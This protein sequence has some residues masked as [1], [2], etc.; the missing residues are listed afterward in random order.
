MKA[1][2]VLRVVL[3]A[4][5]LATALGCDHQSAIPVIAPEMRATAD[6]ARLPFDREARGDGISPTSSVIPPGAQLP[7]GT[8]VTVR[9]K[10]ALSSATALPNDTFE[11]VLEEPVLFNGQVVAERGTAVTGRVIEAK[12]MTPTRTP[13]YLRLAISSIVIHG[14]TS[15][16]RTSS[17][18]LKGSAPGRKRLPVP[19]LNEGALIGAA[20]V[21]KAPS[22]GN[23]MVGSPAVPAFATVPRDVTISPE[24]RLTFRLLEPLP[25]RPN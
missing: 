5:A 20:A 12:P 18:F 9:L 15:S 10:N 4:L 6:A 11:A 14:K 7:P 2:A 19:I 8:V 22:L 13:G 1:T 21:G 24:R 23:A 25:L 17:N 3:L 16:V